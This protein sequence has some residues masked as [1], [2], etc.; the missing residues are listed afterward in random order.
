[1]RTHFAQTM[2]NKMSILNDMIVKNRGSTSFFSENKF[3]LMIVCIKHT[4]KP[5]YI[6]HVD[7]WFLTIYL[8]K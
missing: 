4:L 3:F 8:L 6:E 5:L 1:M 2:R 7:K